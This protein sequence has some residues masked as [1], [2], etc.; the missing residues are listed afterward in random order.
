MQSPHTRILEKLFPDGDC[1]K[2]ML[3]R[4]KYTPLHAA[5]SKG[6]IECMKIIIAS[7]NHIDAVD[8]RGWTPLYIACV[9]N[10]KECVKMLIAA[11]ADVNKSSALG[12]T[13]LHRAC[14]LND[15]EMVQILLEAGAITSV[16]NK[17]NLFPIDLTEHTGIR[18][19]ISNYGGGCATKAAIS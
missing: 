11:G 9:Q 14:V 3:V 1:V 8:D 2:K 10:F 15:L 16:K 4:N 17:S 18:D 13:P 12:W 19:L 7:D 5:C 6:S